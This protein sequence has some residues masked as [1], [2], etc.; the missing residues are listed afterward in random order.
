MSG[1]SDG[2]AGMLANLR[3]DECDDAAV[4]AVDNLD[5]P[6]LARVGAAWW[7][8]LTELAKADPFEAGR[9]AAAMWSHMSA[10]RPESPAPLDA[11]FE[12]TEEVPT[13]RPE[14]GS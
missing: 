7:L 8:R 6:G 5:G 12:P 1:R 11:G 2:I 13:T 10:Y 14:G 4:A 9:L 3:A